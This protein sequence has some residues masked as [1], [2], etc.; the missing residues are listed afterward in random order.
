MRDIKGQRFVMKLGG[1]VMLSA[2]G[3]EALCDD[4]ASLARQGVGVVLMHGGGPQ[5]DALAERLG[6]KARKVQGRRITDDD[7]LEVAKMVYTGSINVELLA[8]LKRHG[9]RGVGISGVDAGLVSV[10]RRPPRLVRDP[11]TGRAEWV[12]FGHVGD[13]E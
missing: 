12:D 3:L 13:I 1:E 6:H 11:A 7:A 10:T 2:P 9:A 5:A 4:V 8:A